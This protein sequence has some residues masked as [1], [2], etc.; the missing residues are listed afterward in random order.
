[1]KPSTASDNVSVRIVANLSEFMF[2][3]T[4]EA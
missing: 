1:V 3:R 2:L 4:Q